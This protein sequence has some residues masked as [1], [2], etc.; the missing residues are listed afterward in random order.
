MSVVAMR[1][2]R[3]QKCRASLARSAPSSLHSATAWLGLG[4]GS[5]LGFGVGVGVGF[6]LGVGLGLGFVV[7]FGFG[8]GL[9]FRAYLVLE[10]LERPHGE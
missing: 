8:L 10:A 4:L 3:R 6:G 2:S 5:G 1:S 7:V 9:G